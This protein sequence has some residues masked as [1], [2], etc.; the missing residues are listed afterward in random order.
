[1]L[2]FTLVSD[3]LM[4]LEARWMGVGGARKKT[5]AD[6]ELRG[7]GAGYHRIIFFFVFFF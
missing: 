4:A 6:Y 7:S 3:D 1:M 5:L 2:G